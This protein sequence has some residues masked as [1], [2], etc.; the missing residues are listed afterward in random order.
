MKG[1]Y[2]VMCRVF[3]TVQVL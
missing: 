3:K 1:K 2:F